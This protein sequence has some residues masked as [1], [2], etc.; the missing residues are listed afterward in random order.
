MATG[1]RFVD[2][3]V[4]KLCVSKQDQRS[5][6][7]FTGPSEDDLHLMTVFQ[8]SWSVMLTWETKPYLSSNPEVGPTCHLLSLG[9]TSLFAPTAHHKK[10]LI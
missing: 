10:A 7:E 9:R 3:K 5:L 2:W 4:R 6:D 8:A 1:E